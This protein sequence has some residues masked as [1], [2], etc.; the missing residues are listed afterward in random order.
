MSATLSPETPQELEPVAICSHISLK[1]RVSEE[2][3]AK[4]ASKS[5]TVYDP[6]LRLQ[7]KIKFKSHP[8]EIRED[9]DE[10]SISVL[11]LR[12]RDETTNTTLSS[13][14]YRRHLTETYSMKKSYS[15]PFLK[16]SLQTLWGLENK[17][18]K[19]LWVAASIPE[20]LEL[21]RY[22]ESSEVVRMF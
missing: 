19:Y 1:S 17:V 18:F 5:H 15:T 2:K 13:D 20:P 4:M 9:R 16:N 21:K 12:F 22:G 10:N 8:A 11:G 14:L 6:T 7:I 3:Y